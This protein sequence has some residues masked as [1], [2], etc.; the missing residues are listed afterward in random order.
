MEHTF[1]VQNV[2]GNLTKMHV[3]FAMCA[4]L[5][6]IHLKHMVNAP[7][8]ERHLKIPGAVA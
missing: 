4:I 5:N 3:G 8:V 6:G 2:D 7:V 1:D